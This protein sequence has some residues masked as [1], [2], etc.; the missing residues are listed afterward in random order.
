MIALMFLISSPAFGLSDSEYRHMMKDLE[1]AAADR[2]LTRAYNEAKRIM[3][4]WVAKQ[5]DIRAKT[6]YD[7]GKGSY[8]HLSLVSRSVKVNGA[9]RRAFTADTNGTYT[10]HYGK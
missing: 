10:R 8:L 3:S 6:F 5:R 9:F 7:N 1:F 2:E 4:D